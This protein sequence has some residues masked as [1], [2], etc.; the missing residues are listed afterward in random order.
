LKPILL[1]NDFKIT[2]MIILFIL[3]FSLVFTGNIPSISADSSTLIVYY[4]FEGD[5]SDS[6]GGSTLTAFG[7]GN[8][9]F[10]HNN[11]TS[12]FGT[13][14][15]ISGDTTYWYWTSTLARGGGFWVDVNS[16]ISS[17]YSVGVRFAFS[18]TGPSWKKI[19][20]YKN[21]SSDTGFYFLSNNLY[22]YNYGGGSTPISN[23]QIID[24]IATRD[25]ASGKFTAYIVIDGHYYKEL[26]VDDPANQAYPMVVGGKTRFGFFFDDIATSAEATSG[27]KVYSIKIWNGPITEEEV[28]EAMDSPDEDGGGGGSL[29]ATDTILI[30]DEPVYIPVRTNQM[31]CW[32][33][34]VNENNNFEFIFRWEY[35]NNNWVKIFD[36]AGN[37]AFSIDMKKGGARFEANLP[38]GMYTVKTFHNDYETPIQEFIIGKP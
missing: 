29:A 12:G 1:K 24:V 10:N 34:W 2:L 17:N 16:S 18:Q 11:A 4:K 14:A 35:A 32:Q 26:E 7:T 27:G 23:N 38:D 21:M 30:L 33:V 3:T 37:E 5:L 9:G 36:L 22:F 28:E 25:G 20:D 13:D 19:I 6:L 31:T 8:D 15:G